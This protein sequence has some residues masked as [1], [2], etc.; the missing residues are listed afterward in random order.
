MRDL[1]VQSRVVATAPHPFGFKEDYLL[2]DAPGLAGDVRRF[3]IWARVSGS[4]VFHSHDVHV[5]GF[6][7]LRWRRALVVH[8][9]SPVVT[10]RVDGAALSFV[11]LPGAVKVV[12]D[13][14]W[15]P[16]PARTAEFRPHG[17]PLRRVLRVGFSLG[18]TD[19]HKLRLIPRAA[20]DEAVAACLGKAEA[21]PLCGVVDHAGMAEY[22]RQIDIWVD[23][24]GTGFY[25]FAAVE[26]ASAGVPVVTQIGAFEREFVPSCPFVSVSRDGVTAAVRELVE[27]DGRR[28]E[29]GAAAREFILRVHDSELV[30]RRCLAAYRRF[31]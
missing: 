4:D 15:L 8:Y 17:D 6:A 16:L 10:S 18:T 14:V 19:P 27:D 20:V 1:G 2:P 13:G 31:L 28:R 9:H 21:W 22:Y 24:I 7:R 12:R 30:A 25:G 23:R 26:A 3:L 11:S 5:P 29:L